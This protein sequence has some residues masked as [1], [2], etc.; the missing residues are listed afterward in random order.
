MRQHPLAQLST[1]SMGDPTLNA[2][3][4]HA[5]A[6]IQPAQD[7]H[8]SVVNISTSV[9]VLRPFSFDMMQVRQHLHPAAPLARLQGRPR[10]I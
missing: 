7:H 8:N 9:G 3:P 5:P 10:R 2:A 1:H 6:A 4:S